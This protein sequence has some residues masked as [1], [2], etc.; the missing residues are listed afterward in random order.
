M[1]HF[2]Y[3]CFLYPYA[4][5]FGNS[6]YAIGLFLYPLKVNVNLWFSDVFRGYRK[7]LAA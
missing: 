1:G 2:N 3:N 5:K 7:R 6:I 4:K